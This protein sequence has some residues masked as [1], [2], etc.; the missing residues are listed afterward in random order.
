MQYDTN[1]TW[2]ITR[3]L[4][5]HGLYNKQSMYIHQRKHGMIHMIQK[6]IPQESTR[7]GNKPQVPPQAHKCSLVERLCKDV[8]KLILGTDMTQH[9][10]PFL[11]IVSQEM[12]P[13]FFVFGSI[14]KHWVFCYAYGTSAITKKWDLGALLT[15]VSQSVWDPQ[16]LGTTT[17]GCNILRLGGGLSYT[18]LLAGR[19][20]NQRGPKKLASTRSRLPLDSATSKIRIRKTMKWKSR[21][22]RMPKA[23]TWGRL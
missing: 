5:Y 17:R 2:Y 12:I 14:M 13:H 7:K 3:W 11:H 18:R 19:P 6:E 15:K 22:G 10:G 21:G 23:K 20:R 9:N 16:Q 8:C 1:A 4:S